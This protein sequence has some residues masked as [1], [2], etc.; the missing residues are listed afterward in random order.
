MA[1]HSSMPW[2]GKRPQIT[3]LLALQGL[4]VTPL[5]SPV[6]VE[7]ERMELD[8]MQLSRQPYQGLCPVEATVRRST[9]N[10]VFPPGTLWVPAAQP[11][12][13]L[14]IQLLEPEAPDSMVSWGLVSSVVE[15]KEYIDTRN[16]EAWARSA[17]RDPAVASA[18]HKTLADQEFA[19]D[20]TARKSWWV[21]RT[22]YWQVQEIGVL[23]VFRVTSAVAVRAALAAT[24][25]TRGD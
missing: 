16:L 13:E 5:A 20:A 21:R 7:V 25:V 8:T 11:D 9:E 3:E 18:W 4:V 14:A 15:Q 19:A 2:Q 22:P 10:R 23:P 1:R 6:T 24:G 12:F 17:L